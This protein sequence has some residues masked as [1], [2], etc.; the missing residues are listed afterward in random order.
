MMQDVRR[1]AALLI[2]SATATIFALVSDGVGQAAGATAGQAGAR[3]AAAA[4]TWTTAMEV[5]GTA[6][7]NKGKHASVFSVSCA[8]A[9]NCGAGGYYT[10]GAGSSTD[11]QAFVVNQ[12]HGAWQ[13]AIA[14]PGTAA[15]NKDDFAQLYSV[16]CASP[17]NCSAGGFYTDGSANAQAFVVNEVNGTWQNAI[18]LP[19]TAA[20]NKGGD[21][22]F[23][24]VSCAS[25]GNCSAGGFYTDGSGH[26]QAFVARQVNGTWQNAIELPGS[27][28]LNKGGDAGAAVLCTSAGD[29]I[30][31]GDYTDSSGHP[32]AFVAN[33]VNGTWQN[34]IEVPGTAALNSGANAGAG[35]ESMSCGSAGNCSA[36]GYYTDSS[37]SLQAFVVNEVDGTWQKAIEVPG[38]ATLNKDGYA[39]AGSVS[40]GSAG[41]CSAGGY[42]TDG[43]GHGQAFVVNEVNGT[44]QKAIE[45]PGTATLNKGG[46]AEVDSVSCK[47]AAN[48]SAGGTYTNSSG[49]QQAFVVDSS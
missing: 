19:G 31:G 10:A 25:A 3:A 20:L 4:G 37:K 14:V 15:L 1:C 16:S 45:V 11:W 27:A 29:C 33:E 28:A 26:A 35:V 34:A 41:N 48:C 21:A 43:S 5:P 13:T 12:V 38:T 2:V 36:S 42:Y 7:L 22:Y 24:S 18:E 30:A 6:A 49:N 44:W 47:S 46:G 17:G 32:Q 23:D 40:C 8:S 9:G 39:Q